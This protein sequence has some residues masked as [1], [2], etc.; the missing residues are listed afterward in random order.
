MTD[1]KKFVTYKGSRVIEGWPQK[2][3]AAQE[4]THYFIGENRYRRIPYGSE[5]GLRGIDI[6]YYCHDCHAEIGQYHVSGCDVEECPKCGH[7]SISCDCDDEGIDDNSFN[8]KRHREQAIAEYAPK[9]LLYDRFATC[10]QH[11]AAQALQRADIKYSSVEARSKEP[12]SFGDKAA[13]PSENDRSKPKYADPLRDITDLAGVR[14][15]VFI[16][17]SVTA[18]DKILSTE[19]EVVERSDKSETLRQDNRFG[20]ASVHYLIRLSPARKSLAEYAEF[21]ALIAEVQVRTVLQHSWAAMSHE[22]E[23]KS[24]AVVPADIL[25]RFRSLAA[26]LEVADREFEEIQ[27]TDRRLRK[28]AQELIKNDILE[29]V[30]I[31]P[32]AVRA[33]LLQKFGSDK[34]LK[35]DTFDYLARMLRRLGFRTLAEVD[36]CIEGYDCD[37][38]GRLIFGSRLNPGWRLQAGLLAAMGEVFLERHP[39]AEEVEAQTYIGASKKLLEENHIMPRPREQLPTTHD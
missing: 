36:G 27:A 30:E 7:Q 29:N 10:I 35:W 26:V 1:E 17:A 19:F 6:R 12:D 2:I 22:I 14:I 11:I 15:I 20:Y 33:Y 23:Y 18:V 38:I 28:E 32:D 21:S 24:S 4:D 3:R 34:R 5:I 37:A 25:R 9:R 8:F 16:P 13:T 39:L 31:T